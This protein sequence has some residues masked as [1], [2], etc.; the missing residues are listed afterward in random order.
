[1]RIQHNSMKVNDWIYKRTVTRSYMTTK[2]WSTS[3]AATDPE[4]SGLGQCLQVSL[5][6]ILP[7]NWGWIRENKICPLPQPHHVRWQP[8]LPNSLQSEH[9]WNLPPPSSPTVKLSHCPTLNAIESLP[10]ACE[11]WLD[12]ASS[13]YRASVYCH[14]GIFNYFHRSI[15]WESS[16]HIELKIEYF[17][18]YYY[19]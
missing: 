12:R 3:S 15:L 18:F 19:L 11:S 1:M 5:F 7:S 16:G 2:L 6:F 13:K 10:S 8:P 17:L 9:I 14:L 4:H